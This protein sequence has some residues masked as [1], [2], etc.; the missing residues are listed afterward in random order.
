MVWHYQPVLSKIYVVIWHHYATMIWYHSSVLLR[1]I[2]YEFSPKKIKKLLVWYCSNHMGQCAKFSCINRQDIDR[3]SGFSPG[4]L[5]RFIWWN[6]P[7]DL[8]LLQILM[9]PRQ[10]H[11]RF[12]VTDEGTLIIEPVRKEDAGEYVCQALS[13]AGSAFAMAKITVKGGLY[14]KVCHLTQ[15]GLVMPYS[16]T[17]LGQY[18]LR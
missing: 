8:T 1:C 6:I 14:E 4:F 5:F 17:E 3:Y 15:C 10:D 9:F 7:N 16:N 11:G 12:S 18:W 13:V 2:L